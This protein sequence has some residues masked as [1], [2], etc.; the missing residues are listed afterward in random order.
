M[1]NTLLSGNR[2]CTL[3]IPC[4]NEEQR[5]PL[6]ALRVF[7]EQTSEIRFLFVND[8]SSDGTLALLRT[9][10][11]E[12][13]ASVDVLDMP[14]NQGK[15]EA[16]RCGMLRAIEVHHAVYTGF[17]DADLATPLSELPRLLHLLVSK[18]EVEILLGS[19][20][21]LLGRFVSRK[22]MR[23]YSGRVFATLAS[24]TLSLPIY[25]TQ[26]GSKLFRVT[27]A[28]REMLATP[29]HSRWIFDVEMLARFL[30]AHASDTDRGA[31]KIYEEPLQ[32]WEDVGGSKLK[33]QD[34]FKALGDLL[35]IR[36]T[37]FSKS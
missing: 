35:L 37:Y 15:A 30:R 36:R 1:N 5:L 4:Y 6:A 27:P 8:G 23:H 7:L 2:S 20:V 14:R 24:L 13:P 11:K 3:V 31:G 16:V 34:S 25:D 18:D 9:F 29:F 19:R 17:W 28:I 22:P 12:F 26:C 21:R 33:P 32:Q 10:E